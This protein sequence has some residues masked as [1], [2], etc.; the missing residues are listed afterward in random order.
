MV[1]RVATDVIRKQEKHPLFDY[2]KG[3]YQ[4]LL[5]AC[6]GCGEMVRAVSQGQAVSLLQ[7]EAKISG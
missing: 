3:E 6:S 5:R 4:A 2:M 1:L 7:N